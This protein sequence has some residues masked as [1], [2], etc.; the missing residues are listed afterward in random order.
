MVHNGMASSGKPY[1]SVVIP[2]LNERDNIRKAISGIAAILRGY[3][4]EILVVD[5]MSTDGTAEIA[6]GLGAKVAYDSHGKGSALIKGFSKAKGKIIISMDADLSHRPS[7]LRLLIAG[8]ETGYDVC[9]GSRFLTGGG[10]EDM[11]LVRKL[12]NKFFLMLVNV[13]F[14][15]TY[16][17]LCYGYRAFSR[18]AMRKMVLS[19]KGFGI[20]TEISIK[21]RKANLRILEVPSYEKKREDGEAKLQTFKDGYAILKTILNN[22]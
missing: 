22:V 11:P 2:T 19:E 20:E 15:S 16:S 21:A 13:L 6:R 1:V 8:I 12:G 7:E 5:G 4:Y 3:N 17:D 18:A 10:T 9:M 14:G